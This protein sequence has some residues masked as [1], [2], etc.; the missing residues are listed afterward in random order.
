MTGAQAP[1]AFSIRQARQLV[2]DLLERKAPI[3]WLDLLASTA[4]TYG[5]AAW[6]L[7]ADTVSAGAIA[8]FTVA[9]FGLYRIGTFMHEIVHI[10][11]GEMRGFKLAWNLVFGLPWLMPSPMYDSH[12]DHHSSFRYGTPQDAEY[13]P[14][15][16]SPA[17]EL[18]RFLAV[19]PL[20]PLLA[21]A[22]FLL[23]SPAAWVAAPLR[24]WTLARASSLACNPHYTQP[25]RSRAWRRRW[26]LIE[27]VLFLYLGGW[28]AA[29][30]TGQVSAGLLLEL[31][32]LITCAVGIN[33][34]RTLAAHHYRN[35]GR[36]IGQVDQLL[37][38]INLIGPPVLTELLFPLGLR[39]HALHHL[40]PSLPYHALPAAHRRLMQRLPPDSPY[41]R[42][43]RTSFAGVLRE[44]WRD[45]RES[46]RRG[47]D[48]SRLWRGA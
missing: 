18:L 27:A 31:Y 36:P 48:A 14:L 44:L 29:L 17:R 42:T 47:V 5:A 11:A 34:V 8:A 45:A 30:A 24:R 39:Y 16:A 19:L 22:R 35:E 10:P 1:P 7:L 21:V 4:V 23:L 43:V 25:P 32:L 28:T 15:G 41:R 12:K 13:L 33:W 9:A 46:G 26:Y 3:Y 6:F 37:D 2:A 38:S 40:M 20:L